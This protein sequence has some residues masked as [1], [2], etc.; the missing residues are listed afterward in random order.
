MQQQCKF[1]HEILLIEANRQCPAAHAGSC[2][3]V[4]LLVL[5]LFAFALGQLFAFPLPLLLL[6]GKILSNLK[7]PAH[8]PHALDRAGKYACFMT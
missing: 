7:W 2:A 4:H 6:H 1:L 8:N 3:T 5:V